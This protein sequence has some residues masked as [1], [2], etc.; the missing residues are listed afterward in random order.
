MTTHAARCLCDP[1]DTATGPMG[2][3]RSSPANHGD[4]RYGVKRPHLL[5]HERTVIGVRRDN[6]KRTRWDGP[7]HASETASVRQG[8]VARKSR[9]RVDRTACATIAPP[10]AGASGEHRAGPGECVCVADRIN[11]YAWSA[12]GAVSW[13]PRKRS[14]GAPD[15]LS[16]AVWIGPERARR[17]RAGGSRYG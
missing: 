10:I 13:R 3:R 7:H 9:R 1:V 2:S 11:G 15:R 8:G 16:T 4:V 12:C 14:S 5:Q 17:W 6:L